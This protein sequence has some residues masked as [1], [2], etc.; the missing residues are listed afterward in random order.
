MGG[1]KTTGVYPIDRNAINI[2]AKD[3]VANNE[4]GFIPLCSPMPS[5]LEKPRKLPTFTEVELERFQ[6]RYELE[7]Q[8]PQ[9]GNRYQQWVKMYHPNQQIEQPDTTS[10]AMK[11][12][13]SAPSSEI[14]KFF[15]ALPSP[16]LPSVKSTSCGRVLTSCESL[17]LLEEKKQ[18]KEE[19]LKK[20]G[21]KKAKRGAE[22]AKRAAAIDCKESAE[23][24]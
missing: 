22:D 6:D 2:K 19:I 5:A 3:I 23:E 21:A 14:D 10:S 4:L 9:D 20:G 17:K 16:V 15:P 7:A 1:F 12:L 8:N 24:N 11:V 18:K 13:M